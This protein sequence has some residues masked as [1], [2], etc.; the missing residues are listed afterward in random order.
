ME[1]GN[2][3]PKLADDLN[4]FV[5]QMSAFC[6]ELEAY[7]DT[8]D[9]DIFVVLIRALEANRFATAA[10]LR[11]AWSEE[12]EA[13]PD[14][15][16][17]ARVYVMHHLLG[18]EWHVVFLHL[19]LRDYNDNFRDDTPEE[20]PLYGDDVEEVESFWERTFR[21]FD[22]KR[23]REEAAARAWMNRRAKKAA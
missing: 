17:I 7:L 10:D 22:S 15:D 11:K 23:Q 14:D 12:L 5:H 16:V 8:D 20:C 21:D 9:P 1:L 4:G 19:Y 3:T 6:R 13:E 18:P 2:C